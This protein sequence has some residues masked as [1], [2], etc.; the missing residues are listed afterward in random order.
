MWGDSA[1]NW[2]RTG[3]Q[4]FGE[5]ALGLG[6]AE[7]GRRDVLGVLGNHPARQAQ[8]WA[9]EATV[10][11]LPE[12]ERTWGLALLPRGSQ[13]P[14]HS[15][16]WRRAPGAS[17]ARL[18]GSCLCWTEVWSP[19]VQPVSGEPGPGFP[20]GAGGPPVTPRGHMEAVRGSRPGL[21]ACPAMQRTSVQDSG[22]EPRLVPVLQKPT[23]ES[24]VIPA[25][26]GGSRGGWAMPP[27]QRGAHAPSSGHD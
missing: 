25:W 22:W 18:A 27:G 8:L 6:G 1:R 21:G 10:P 20:P 5:G 4:R 13:P 23:Q 2:G 14:R 17:P 7:Q 9:G 12:W 24:Q 3:G 26:M 16:G 11:E 15:A 19:C